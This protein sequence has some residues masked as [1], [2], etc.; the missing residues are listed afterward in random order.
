MINSKKT[1][2]QKIVSIIVK[3]IMI[4]MS[5]MMNKINKNQIIYKYNKK[6]KRIEV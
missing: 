3:I 4:K 1:K 2:I 6:M 5:L